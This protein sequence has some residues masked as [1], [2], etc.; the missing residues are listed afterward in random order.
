MSHPKCHWVSSPVAFVVTKGGLT[1]PKSG[2]SLSKAAGDVIL[3]A[4]TVQ[5]DTL[6]IGRFAV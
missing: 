3:G 5:K 2:D 1:N 4:F 6:L